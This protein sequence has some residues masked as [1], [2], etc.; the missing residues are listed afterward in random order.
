MLNKNDKSWPEKK[1]DKFKVDV[2]LRTYI[3]FSTA[4]K[5]Y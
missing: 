3:V 5:I 1:R 2:E 4:L